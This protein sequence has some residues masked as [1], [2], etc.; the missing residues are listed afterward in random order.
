[1]L[2]E[3]YA[4]HVVE[5][6]T[7]DTDRGLAADTGDDDVQ[8][9]VGQAEQSRNGE[10]CR[11]KDGD[12]CHCGV[13]A[14]VGRDQMVD[15][16]GDWPRLEKLQT[17]DGES[18]PDRRR[19][20]RTLAAQRRPERSER[21]SQLGPGQIDGATPPEP[22]QADLGSRSFRARRQRSRCVRLPR[23]RSWL[24]V[25]ALAHFCRALLACGASSEQ[26]RNRLCQR[27]LIVG[28]DDHTGIADERGDIALA[29]DT[30]GSPAAR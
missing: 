19:N 3:I 28:V 22:H 25:P 2:G 6:V 4:L 14:L 5:D 9:F 20:A 10:R 1:M 21:A 24:R 23:T 11:R 16:Q 13:A 17:C 18:E 27:V 12:R 15:H 30:T 29:V 26:L 7:A 8:P